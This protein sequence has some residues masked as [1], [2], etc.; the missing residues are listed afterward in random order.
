MTLVEQPPPAALGLDADSSVLDDGGVTAAILEDVLGDAISEHE[1]QT[2]DTAHTD[3]AEST[4]NGDETDDAAAPIA[5]ADGDKEAAPEPAAPKAKDRGE[6]KENGQKSEGGVKKVLKSG[7]FG[8]EWTT[9]FCVFPQYTRTDEPQLR[10][11]PSLLP[12]AR[13]LAVSLAS[14]PSR[15]ARRS[16]T[17]SP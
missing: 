16:R 9:T 8:G 10:Q 14:L 12:V 5:V 3:N 13:S 15:P 6:D 2:D 4:L 17:A 1:P 11:R 7:V